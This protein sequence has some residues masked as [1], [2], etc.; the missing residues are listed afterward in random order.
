MPL[1]IRQWPQPMSNLVPLVDVPARSA[2]HGAPML[3][4]VVPCY[5]ERPNVAPLIARLD[6]AL[7]G[8]AWEV[9]YVDDNS[10]DGTTAEVR[11]IAQTDSRVRC[12]RRIDRRGL[13]SAVIEGGLSSSAQYVAVI[14]GDLQHDETRLPDM[15]AALQTGRYDLA[16][17]SRHIEGGDDAGLSG[18]WRHLLSDGGIRLAQIFLPVKLT[19][20]MSGFFM[21]PRPLF[22]QLAGSLTGQGFKILLDLA[23]SSPAPLRVVE[24][25]CVFH[26]RVAGES[27]LDALVLAQFAGL[28][29]DK[30]FGGLL[31]LRFISFALVG[32]LGVL[33]HLAVLTV[34]LK[35]VGLGFE[36]AQASATVVAMV[37]NFQLNNEI[38]YR[39]QRLRGP[40]LWRGLLVFIVVCGV[41]AVANIGIAK[42]LYDTHTNWTIA[43]AIGAIIGVVWNF[44]VSATLVWRAR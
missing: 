25:P 32:A 23:L 11:R 22:E 13:S 3:T 33:V 1:A 35:F 18:R 17:G 8:I 6:A 44:A 16:V 39:D 21:L 43:G 40:R 14:D 7:Y 19:D 34:A 37:F 12:I 20:P 9:V 26:E 24:I 42:S 5:N 31:P 28:L 27:K 38:T 36:A 30:V 2:S 10:P 29:L 15:L 4:V 41:G